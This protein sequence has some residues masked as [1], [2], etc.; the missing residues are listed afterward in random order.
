VVR[1]HAFAQTAIFAGSNILVGLLGMISTAVLAR[2]LGPDEFGRYA[3]AVS[4][5]VFASMFF[6]FGV[7]LPAAR[8]AAT[9]SD[10][11]EARRVVGAS[12]LLF[13]PIGL[14]FAATIFGLSFVTDAIFHTHVGHELRVV[15]PLLAVY[16]F[17]A[18]SVQLS[19][20][21]DRLH[22]SSVTAVLSQ[23]AFLVFVVLAVTVAGNLGVTAGLALRALAFMLGLAVF[24]LWIR[25]VFR[26][27]R[28]CFAPLLRQVRAYGFSVYIG[29]VLSMS[30]YSM[31]TLMLAAFTNA[32]TV[33]FYTLAGAIAYASGLPVTGM[34][35]ALFARM[36]RRSDLDRRWLVVAWSVGSAAVVLTVALAL[37]F[38]H[39]VFSSDYTAVYPLV[40]PLALAQLIRGVTTVYNSFLSAHGRGRELRN[41][42]C[43]LTI[44][45]IVLNF[46]LIPTF[47]ATGAAWASFVALVFN[48]L[49]HVFYYRQAVNATSLA[50][51]T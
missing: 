17:I 3:F 45:N 18:A 24:V 44:S 33:G 26:G 38:L 43:V 40:L 8:L 35:T 9:S 37:P 13:V 21:V 19:Q 30:T 7:S 49:A 39:I 15:S 22:V 48:F 36:A 16:P 50:V 10:T 41:A 42:A 25:P 12:L 27:I 1:S 14:V 47:G 11:T 29:R 4:F 51:A 32:R 6:E 5:V 28:S 31:D 20:G 23:A 34:A 2:H 46:A